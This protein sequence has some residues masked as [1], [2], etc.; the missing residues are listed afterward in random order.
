M[1]FGSL[2]H[3]EIDFNEKGDKESISTKYFGSLML[4]LFWLTYGS[5]FQTTSLWVKTVCQVLHLIVFYVL[6]YSWL[7][8][9]MSKNTRYFSCNEGF[10]PMTLWRITG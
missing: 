8:H 6:S 5:H 7:D 4:L 1:V 3:K 2:V 9:V 10:I